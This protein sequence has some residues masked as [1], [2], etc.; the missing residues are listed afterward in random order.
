M[1]AAQW[2]MPALIIICAV[3]WIATLVK[4][5]CKTRHLTGNKLCAIIYAQSEFTDYWSTAMADYRVSKQ[6]KFW[7]VTRTD[8]TAWIGKVQ[9]RRE[10]INIARLLAGRAGTVTVVRGGK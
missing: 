1:D 8:R 7:V 3:I 4:F 2:M 9:L 6:G 5:L 10:A